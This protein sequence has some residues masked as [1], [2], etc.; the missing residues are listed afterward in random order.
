[1]GSMKRTK[2]SRGQD[3][4]SRGPIHLTQ[5]DLVEVVGSDVYLQ[6]PRGSNNSGSGSGSGSGG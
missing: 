6:Y 4:R 3:S 5:V 1:M 2:Q